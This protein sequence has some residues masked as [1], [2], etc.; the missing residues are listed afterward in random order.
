MRKKYTTYLICGALL[1]QLTA[2]QI[3]TQQ[4]LRKP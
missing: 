2:C 4:S 3:P 1:L